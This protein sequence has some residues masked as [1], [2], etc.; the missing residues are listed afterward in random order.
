[1]E[2]NRSGLRLTWI[3]A[4]WAL[5]I[6]ML[7][8]GGSGGTPPPAS[9]ASANCPVPVAIANPSW[10]RDVYPAIQ[11]SC[12]T[13]SLSCHGT[14]A[15]RISYNLAAS[16]LRGAL[17]NKPSPVMTTPGW[18]YIQAGD[19]LS[20]T[21]RRSWLYEKVDPLVADGPGQAVT[22]SA[23]GGRMPAGSSLCQPT[24]ETLKAWIQQG[25]LDN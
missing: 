1:M 18:V 15:P 14:D 20:A 7:S 3:G 8:C 16:V 25:A 22:G 23:I 10:K 19:D 5:P 11:A 6:W 4:M 17:V 9:V 12:G 24:I 2:A 13:Q 21:H